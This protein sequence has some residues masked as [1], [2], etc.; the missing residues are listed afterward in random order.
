MSIADI[1]GDGQP[2][3]IATAFQ[4]LWVYDNHGQIKWTRDYGVPGAR[5]SSRASARHSFDLDGDGIA[6][7]IIP[8][9]VGMEFTDGATGKTKA[10]LLW[11]DIFAQPG[12]ANCGSYQGGFGASAIVA[13]VDGS[14]HA[15]VVVSYP[16]DQYPQPGC[17]FVFGAKNNDWRPAPTVFN[18]FGYHGSNVDNKG[19]I[20]S[21]EANNFATPATNVY[22]N[23]PQV[24]T[25]VDPKVNTT[26]TFQYTAS[27]ASMTSAPA[28]VTITLL[29]DNRP[30]VFKSVPPTEYQSGPLTYAAHAVDPDPGDTV[31]Y[32]IVLTAGNGAYNCSID[33]VSGVLTCPNLP[34][35]AQFIVLAATDNHGAVANQTLSLL[36]STGP[37]TVPNIVGQSR[38]TAEATLAA[39]GFVTGSVT[40]IYYPAPADQVLTQFPAAGATALLGSAITLQ[41]SLGLQPQLIPDLVGL[42]LTQ[43]RTALVGLGFT[44]IVNPGVVADR[45]GK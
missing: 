41:V 32:S 33:A 30:P 11:S 28:T 25:P 8:T 35:G 18:E 22:G 24:L 13:D 1:D 29:P 16:G 7:I 36:Q 21:V 2:E 17:V 40:S 6:E 27:T 26:T 9:S 15:S 12:L 31:S 4:T 3:I 5:R 20:P 44:V 42:T 38:T 10:T 45:T 37:G 34:S 39:A 23:Q 14:G 19:T 43:A